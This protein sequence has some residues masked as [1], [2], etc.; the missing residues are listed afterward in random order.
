MG[1]YADLN[2]EMK[3]QQQ[4]EAMHTLPATISAIGVVPHMLYK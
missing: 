4:V 3:Q 1:K 2:T